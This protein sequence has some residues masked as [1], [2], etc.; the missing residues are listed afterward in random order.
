M[1]F[2]AVVCVGSTRASAECSRTD[3]VHFHG[4]NVVI[5]VGPTYTSCL[6]EDRPAIEIQLGSMNIKQGKCGV[7]K[8]GLSKPRF[9][10]SNLVQETIPRSTHP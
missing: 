2:D 9:V 8:F 1:N 6:L 3:D 7:S 4:T 10:H 5:S